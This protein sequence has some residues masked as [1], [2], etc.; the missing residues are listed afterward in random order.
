MT[1]K[2]DLEG[3]NNAQAI[4]VGQLLAFVER[5]ERLDEEKQTITDDQKEIISE[6]KGSGFDTKAFKEMIK[7]RKLESAERKEREALRT[8]YAEA[9]GVFG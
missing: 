3:G 5:Y 8:I 2:P 9:L 7:L 4:A 6:L 1:E